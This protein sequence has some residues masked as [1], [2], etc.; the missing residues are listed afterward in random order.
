MAKVMVVPLSS[1]SVIATQLTEPS[2]GSSVIWPKG[3]T[4]K[5]QRNF[6]CLLVCPSPA[7]LKEEG[8]HTSSSVGDSLLPAVG[9]GATILFRKPGLRRAKA[10]TSTI[11]EEAMMSSQ[12]GS[13]SQSPEV[14][15]VCLVA[16]ARG[17]IYHPDSYESQGQPKRCQEISPHVVTLYL[18]TNHLRYGPG[19]SCYCW[20]IIAKLL[21]D[22]W[23]TTTSPSNVSVG[24]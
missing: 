17:L 13:S 22:Q 6:S 9:Y 19:C 2:L 23:W 15:C 7:T 1:S 11:V 8:W 14:G 20:M 12:E 5:G 10:T 16:A 21:H 3:P 18:K 24:V 4:S